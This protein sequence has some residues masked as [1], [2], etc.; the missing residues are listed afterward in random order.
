LF[1]FQKYL[2]VIRDAFYRD[3]CATSTPFSHCEIGHIQEI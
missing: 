3:S 2:I 1:A